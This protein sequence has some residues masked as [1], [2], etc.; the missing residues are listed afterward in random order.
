MKKTVRII[1][2]VMA[3]AMFISL[4]ACAKQSTD[5]V[6]TAY[7][8]VENM[9]E[10]DIEALKNTTAPTTVAPTTNPDTGETETTTSIAQAPAPA[11]KAEI[12]QYYNLATAK[13]AAEKVAFAKTRSTVEKS[14][15]AGVA[16]KTFKGVVYK[17]MG[18]G[19]DN[20]YS[21]NVA[22]NDENYDRYIKAATLTEEDITDASITKSGNDYVITIKIKAGS[23]SING[24]EK[25][26]LYAPIDKSG[27]GNGLNDKDYYD[28]K[29]AQNVYDAIDDV[30]A[31]ANVVEKYE[32]AVLTATIDSAT[33]N[34]K[35]IKV[36]FDM[37][38]D[39]TNVLASEGH[40]SGTT[41]AEF[42]DFKW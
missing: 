12:L 29:T 22:K 36:V 40:A 41:T 27:V 9:S 37:S 21:V 32:N 26:M 28:H 15:E 18:I 6:T 10:I 24:G 42:K 19:A 17:F 7:E 33:G 23:S 35:N 4:C 25:Y 1:S 11:T 20:V 5:L 34:I 13:V 14:Y 39:I 31:K 16:L 3:A 2:L 8:G 30:A 38:F